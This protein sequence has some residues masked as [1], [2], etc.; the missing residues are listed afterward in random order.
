MNQKILDN[1]DWTGRKHSEESKRK[2][3][4]KLK[5]RKLSEE[6][7]KNVGKAFKGEKHPN[8]KG[9]DVGYFQNHSYIRKTYGKADECWN[10]DFENISNKYHWANISGKYLRDVRDW[11]KLC[12]K[13]HSM[14]DHG[15]IEL[16]LKERIKI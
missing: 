11:T 6:H 3:S 13:C 8:W 9:D 1:L 10:L 4:L 15:L 2:I 16:N 12:V 5:G 7:R 14:Y